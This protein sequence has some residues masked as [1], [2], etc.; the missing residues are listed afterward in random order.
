MRGK[1]AHEF[2]IAAAAEPQLSTAYAP[3][4]ES[5][6]AALRER[7]PPRDL[8]AVLRATGRRLAMRRPAARDTFTE[9]AAAAARALDDFGGAFT[10]STLDDRIVL[11]SAICPLAM[12]TAGSHEGCHALAEF[13]GEVAAAPVRHRCNHDGRPRCIFELMGETAAPDASGHSGE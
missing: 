8:I 3:L 13:A 2:R 1:P 5:L 4:A 6:I 11:S 9:R 12:I 10:S 7:I